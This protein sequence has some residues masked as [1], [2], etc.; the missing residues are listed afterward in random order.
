[1]IGSLGE[2]R[3]HLKKQNVKTSWFWSA[4]AIRLVIGA[5]SIKVTK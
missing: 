2:E 5:M 1:L 3:K 4:S